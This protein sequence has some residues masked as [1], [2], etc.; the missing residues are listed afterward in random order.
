MYHARR[1]IANLFGDGEPWTLPTG[2]CRP[3]EAMLRPFKWAN[4]MCLSRR[5]VGRANHRRSG[6]WYESGIRP[7]M[8]LTNHAYVVIAITADPG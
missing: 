6:L 3:S 7:W 8:F 5:A 4:E 1:P 2:G